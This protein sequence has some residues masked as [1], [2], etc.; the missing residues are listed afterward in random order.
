MYAVSQKGEP[1][2]KP[3]ITHRG[4]PYNES[5]EATDDILTFDNFGIHTHVC[6]RVR[7]LRNIK[8]GVDDAGRQHCLRRSESDIGT[9]GANAK[10]KIY[11]RPA[12][13][14]TTRS[15]SAAWRHNEFL[16]QHDVLLMP[17]RYGLQQH[18]QFERLRPER[19]VQ[20]G[21]RRV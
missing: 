7:R 2:K 1:K 8:V 6:H 16:L 4:G 20:Y 15:Y 5:G 11:E 17:R 12:S 21:E 18:V 10:V 3:R 19:R 13:S 14:G 9:R